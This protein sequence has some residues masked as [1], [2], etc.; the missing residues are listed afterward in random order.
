M[1]EGLECAA[2]CD[3]VVRGRIVMLAD[4]YSAPSPQFQGVRHY[5]AMKE[6]GSSTEF[7]LLHP[8]CFEEF[9]REVMRQETHIVLMFVVGDVGTIKEAIGAG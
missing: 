5:Q 6:D 8:T 2:N 9:F 1:E 7:I 3:E 4:E